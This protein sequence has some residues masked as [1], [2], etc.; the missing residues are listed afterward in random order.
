MTDLCSVLFQRSVKEGDTYSKGLEK[1]RINVGRPVR[2]FS[3][4]CWNSC[5]SIQCEDTE[6]PDVKCNAIYTF[7]STQRNT[8]F[9]WFEVSGKS[10]AAE[11]MSAR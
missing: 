1:E 4:I 11:R 7:N 8:Y 6:G 9:R 10:T 2:G 3:Q 5:P